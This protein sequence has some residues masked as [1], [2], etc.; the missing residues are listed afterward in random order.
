MYNA[1]LLL[2]PLEPCAGRDNQPK[3]SSTGESPKLPCRRRIS[4]LTLMAA[5]GTVLLRSSAAFSQNI[6]N[7][8]DLQTAIASKAT[9]LNILA[10][11]ITWPTATS[12]LIIDYNPE[13]TT[14]LTTVV[15]DG[16]SLSTLFD[17]SFPNTANW[18]GSFTFINGT[19]PGNGGAIGLSSSVFRGL[20]TFTNN[21]ADLAGGGVFVDQS[22]TFNGP[23]I[24]FENST[25]NLGGGMYVDTN[26][27][28]IFNQPVTFS[29][30]TADE[31]GGLRSFGGKIIFE[32]K[33]T[34]IGNGAKTSGGGI[35]GEGITTTITFNNAATFSGNSPQGIYLAGGATL[36]LNP[37][38][39]A[40]IDIQDGVASDMSAVVINK[41]GPG[42]WQMAG[43][44]SGYNGATRI[45]EGIFQLQP[46]AVYGNTT[47]GSVAIDGGTLVFNVQPGN[48]P[49]LQGQNIRFDGSTASVTGSVNGLL[50]STVAQAMNPIVVNGNEAIPG[51]ALNAGTFPNSPYGWQ[52]VFASKTALNLMITPKT[53]PEEGDESDINLEETLN[54]INT[55]LNLGLLAQYL[56]GILRATNQR[57]QIARICALTGEPLTG[58]YTLLLNGLLTF[59]EQVEERL[60][61]PLVTEQEVTAKSVLSTSKDKLLPLTYGAHTPWVG[62]G[63]IIGGAGRQ[64]PVNGSNA[65]DSQFVGL[66]AGFD[67]ALDP[68]W[69]L[70][71][72]LNLQ[73]GILDWDYNAETRANTLAGALYGSY[74]QKSWF[75]RSLV[76]GGGSWVKNR[77]EIPLAF[78]GLPTVTASS[79]PTL[80]F[81]NARVSS[82]Y[83]FYHKDFRLTPSAGLFYVHT[84][85][86]PFSESGADEL[87]LRATRTSQDNLQAQANLEALY[88]ANINDRPVTLRANYGIS[89][90]TLDKQANITTRFLAFPDLTTFDA[91]APSPGRLRQIAEVGMNVEVAKNVHFYLDYVGIFA[92]HHYNNTGAMGVKVVF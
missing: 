61:S 79:N 37:P 41:T 55:P 81:V 56:L 75:A 50:E 48:W 15:F 84:A 24:F 19:T 46:D 29:N 59:N 64:N 43:N 22:F 13:F 9:P 77:R 44:S 58:A 14:T 80:P 17:I 76:G 11:P 47:S 92:R 88:V 31:G 60:S 10:S 70:G 7:Y 20:A 85:N 34:F 57:E 74:D 21:H 42:T 36:N 2:S 23:A 53:I 72:A 8:N 62:W 3:H 73:R 69:R 45:T 25:F 33:A 86:N 40:L 67:R 71:G 27:Q 91:L 4:S 54:I 89:Y 26:G 5:L 28:V 39:G 16:Q 90:E 38:P 82:G 63:K 35:S 6:F 12:E 32:D 87:N 65:Y 52:L 30:N 78:I 18:N 51:L 83:H 49:L 1:P 68:N 66:I